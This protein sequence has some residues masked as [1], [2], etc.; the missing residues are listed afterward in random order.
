MAAQSIPAFS[1]TVSAYAPQDLA[2]G[3]L[4]FSSAGVADGFYVGALAWLVDGSGMNNALVLIQSIVGAKVGVAFQPWGGA[5]QGYVP[6]LGSALLQTGGIGA[7]NNYGRS[8]LSLS[9]TLKYSVTS[10]AGGTP[11][12]FEAG[13]TVTG[14]TSGATGIVATNSGVNGNLNY[15]GLSGGTPAYFEAGETVTGSTSGTTGVVAVNS[16]TGLAGTLQ[17]VDVSGAFHGTTEVITGGTSGT[18][19]N[20]AAP[21][22]L[23]P[24]GINGVL[25]LV[26]V[27]GT[28]HSST[29]TITGGTSGTTADTA[30]P[31]TLAP[32]GVVNYGSG[33]KLFQYPNQV[34]PK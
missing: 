27:V 17:L 25:Q 5:G 22:I 33:S 31:F 15:S 21:F 28:F 19:A 12:Y 16:G 13:E 18:T 9:G 4:T 20:T 1:A 11:S 3:Y 10:L 8:N 26:G 2:T 32:A 29:E 7:Q 14:G 34:V 6:V 24:T 23:T 30:S